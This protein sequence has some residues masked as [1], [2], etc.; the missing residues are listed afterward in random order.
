MTPAP[1]QIRLK[2]MTALNSR[3]TKTLGLKY[4]LIVAPMAGGPT[5]PELVIAASESGALGFIGAAY[6]SPTALVDF[7]KKVRAGTTKPLGIN[8]FIPTDLPRVSDDALKKAISHTQR[9]RDQWGLSAPRL[10]PPYEE[11]FDAQFE[12]VLSLKPEA[13]SFVFGILDAK[14]IKA[15]RSAGIYIIGTAT[16]REEALA[17]QESGVDAVVAQ[18]SE[19]G[20]HRGMFDASAD[21][22]DITTQ[23]LLRLLKNNIRVPVIAAGGLMT[24]ADIKAALSLGAEAVQM[25]TAFL[26]TEEAGT[27][28]PYRKKLLVSEVRKTKLTRAFSGRLARGIVNRFM[29]EMDAHPEALLPFPAQNKFTRDLRNASVTA[30]SPDFLSLWSGSGKGALWTGTTSELIKNLFADT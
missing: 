8:L 19:A 22:S 29:E 24:S 27:S 18:G 3:L 30:Q 23:D 4:P 12:A 26:A 7:T 1:P 14:Y 28:A 9:F 10:E 5:T 25:G 20:G 6:M 11:D 15:A 21:D 2:S 13:L 16:S 17:L